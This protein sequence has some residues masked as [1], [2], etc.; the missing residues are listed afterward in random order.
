MPQSFGGVPTS[1]AWTLHQ[2]PSGTQTRLILIFLKL[3]RAD[4]SSLADSSYP[5]STGA[6]HRAETGELTEADLRR[7][8]LKYKSDRDSPVLC[9]QRRCPHQMRC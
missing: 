5:A 4:V 7:H 3:L 1:T 9:A 6:H 8:G 2:V